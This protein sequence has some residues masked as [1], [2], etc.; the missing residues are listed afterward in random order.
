MDGV[1]AILTGNQIR[2]PIFDGETK[3]MV[4]DTDSPILDSF[5]D[6]LIES[7]S[8]VHSPSS[9]GSVDLDDEVPTSSSKPQPSSEYTLSTPCLHLL[10]ADD[11]EEEAATTLGHRRDPHVS[12]PRTTGVHTT[13]AAST[14]TVPTPAWSS[15]DRV[16]EFLGESTRSGGRT[17]DARGATTRES[18]SVSLVVYIVNNTFLF[19]FCTC[20]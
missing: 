3:M 2:I 9:G 1:G 8:P 20:M 12:V 10:P 6:D 14:G 5:V 11:D 15:F 18:T 17:T 7:A 19:N 13:A 4:F 16:R